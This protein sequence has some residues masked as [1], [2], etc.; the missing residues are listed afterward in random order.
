[1]LKEGFSQQEIAQRTNVSRSTVQ[2]VEQR[3]LINNPKNPK[4]THLSNKSVLDCF[5][6]LVN[7]ESYTPV[8]P[9]ELRG[10][11]LRRYLDLR[12]QRINQLT[13]A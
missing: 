13:D 2:R 7:S 3:T 9:L 5:N 1:L 8:A 10:D 6:S 11:A 12:N 4:P